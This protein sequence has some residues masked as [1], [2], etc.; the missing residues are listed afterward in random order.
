MKREKIC[1]QLFTEA[2][3]GNQIKKDKIT[4]QNFSQEKF[5]SGFGSTA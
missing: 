3:N 2:G 5:S 4:K 1:V